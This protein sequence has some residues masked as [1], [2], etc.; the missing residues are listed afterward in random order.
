MS[1]NHFRPK[2]NK[3]RVLTHADYTVYSVNALAVRNAAQ[4]DEEF[5][6]FATADEFP[7]LIPKGEIWI[8]EKIAAKEGVFFIANALTQLKRQAD[9][10]AP[11]EAYEEALEVE[12]LLREKLNGVEYRD[13]KPHRQVP[14]EIYLGP[15]VTLPDPQGP[16][17]VWLVDGNLVRSHYKTDYTEGGHGY[18]YPWVPRPEIW[19]EDG[20]DHRELPYI[21]A[22]EYLERRLMRDAGLEYDPAH[23]V[24]S[25]VEFDLR[26]NERVKLF[27]APGRRKVHQKDLVNLTAQELFDYVRKNYVKG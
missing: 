5:G 9:G 16:V 25:T 22:H 2:L 26:K 23:E 12:Q 11:D 21:T 8:S 20:V 4:P 14:E 19:V 18:V 7:D 1:R 10:A 15:Y 17:E 27:L 13:G 24:C 6:N 3:K